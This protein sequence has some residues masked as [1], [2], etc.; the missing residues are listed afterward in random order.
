MSNV[1]EGNLF[2]NQ[3]TA[4]TVDA[5]QYSRDLFPGL[6]RTLSAAISRLYAGLGPPIEQV[7]KIMG[8]CLSF[9]RVVRGT[10]VH[11]IASHP[12]MSY[13]FP[14][15]SVSSVIQGQNDVLF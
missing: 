9:R 6:S 4:P 13:L 2:V 7:N 11:S 14:A 12:H 10:R 15:S 5:A 3:T 8:E 1:N